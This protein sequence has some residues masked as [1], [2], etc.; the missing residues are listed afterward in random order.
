MNNSGSKQPS[1]RLIENSIAADLCG[2]PNI[3]AKNTKH[4]YVVTF[5]P[6]CAGKTI[7]LKTLASRKP[8]IHI[9]SDMLVSDK[10]SRLGL[11]L[12]SAFVEHNTSFFFHFQ[13]E[14]LVTRFYQ[15]IMAPMNA[16]VD[17]TIFSTLAYS[18]ALYQLGWLKQFE[19]ETFFSHYL[20]Y[21]SLLPNPK[22]ILYFY[23]EPE[24]I[25]NRIR[26][27]LVYD[28]FRYHEAFYS[29]QYVETLCS[30]FAD[31]ADELSKIYE[32]MFID[33][34]RMNTEQII[35]AYSLTSLQ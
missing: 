26:K 15:S 2:Y 3:L 11:Y 20:C 30:A 34:D 18:R 14:V 21:Y 19:Y 13:L 8:N 29:K 7:T 32:I 27:R 31:L 9:V 16:F 17:E 4:P 25:A 10:D 6:V 12:Y 22:T 35:D 33:T 23:C 24:T 5:G 28:K 1:I